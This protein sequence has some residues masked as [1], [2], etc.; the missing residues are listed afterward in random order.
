[1]PRQGKLLTEIK[2]SIMTKKQGLPSWSQSWDLSWS[3]PGLIDGTGLNLI[4][5]LDPLTR[6][7]SAGPGPRPVHGT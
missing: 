6:L 2:M 1:M 7:G 5:E 4:P 3:R